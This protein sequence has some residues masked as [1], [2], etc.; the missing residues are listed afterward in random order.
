MLRDVEPDTARGPLSFQYI[1]LA[2]DEN[3]IVV[4]W[5]SVQ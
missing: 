3:D 4:N 1:N 5:Y 2:I